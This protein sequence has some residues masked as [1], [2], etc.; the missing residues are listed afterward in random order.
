LGLDYSDYSKAYKLEAEATHPE[1]KKAVTHSKNY[2]FYKVV[3][4]VAKLAL[5]LLGIAAIVI[6]FEL[7]PVLALTLFAIFTICLAI[8]TDHLKNSGEYKVI[9]FDREVRLA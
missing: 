2:Y 4:T 1:V 7:M 8:Q 9:E 3:T 6:G 5:T